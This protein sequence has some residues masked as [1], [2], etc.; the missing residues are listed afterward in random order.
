MW[1]D[2]S[3]D[4]GRGIYMQLI[5]SLVFG[6]GNIILVKQDKRF[7]LFL[8]EKGPVF[9]L[10]SKLKA[11]GGVPSF[12]HYTKQRVDEKSSLLDGK[13]YHKGRFL[14]LNILAPT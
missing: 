4:N 11:R 8:F 5:V 9:C 12:L 14:A 7:F 13:E 1:S 6:I 3:H 2:V 10:L